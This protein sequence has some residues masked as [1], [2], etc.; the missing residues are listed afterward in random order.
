MLYSY[1]ILYPVSSKF[2]INPNS[3]YVYFDQKNGI[4]YLN[5]GIGYPSTKQNNANVWFALRS[6]HERLKS[7]D[8]SVGAF[9]PIGSKLVKKIS[10]F[11]L[12]N[13]IRFDL[14]IFNITEC[15]NWFFI[16]Y[17]MRCW[18]KDYPFAVRFMGWCFED[19]LIP[20]CLQISHALLQTLSYLKLGNGELWTGHN[21]VILSLNRPSIV[22][23]LSPVV[24]FGITELTGSKNITFQCLINGN[25]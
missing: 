15:W 14:T 13:S 7:W 23:L 17:W 6:I 19:D 18:D 5:D 11:C 24:S 4:V 20:K 10:R 8:S 2:L 9:T 12:F 25:Q 1:R 21:N 3:S 16:N 22:R